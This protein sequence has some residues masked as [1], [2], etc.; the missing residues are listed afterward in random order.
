[1]GLLEWLER[2]WF[3]IGVLLVIFGFGWMISYGVTHQQPSYEQ[4]MLAKGYCQ[5]RTYGGDV[6]W[7]P[8]PK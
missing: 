7:N 5:S 4:Q 6:I 2:N 8:C 1:M 3:P